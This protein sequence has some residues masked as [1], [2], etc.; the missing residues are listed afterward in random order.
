MKAM[1]SVQQTDGRLFVEQP[2]TIPNSFADMFEIQLVIKPIRMT[3]FSGRR[4][5]TVIQ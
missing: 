2:T 5:Y 3:N 1:V 4:T